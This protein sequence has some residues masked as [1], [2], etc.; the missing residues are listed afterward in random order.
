MWLHMCIKK[1]L[2]QWCYTFSLVYSSPLQAVPMLA[3]WHP[4]P[5]PQT[6]AANADFPAELGNP[7]RSSAPATG[8]TLQLCTR[9]TEV[10]EYP[11]SYISLLDSISRKPG[12]G[13]TELGTLNFLNFRS[14]VTLSASKKSSPTSCSRK[15]RFSSCPFCRAESTKIPVRIFLGI[16]CHRPPSTQLDSTCT[17]AK[18]CVSRQDDWKWW[19]CIYTP[20]R[21]NAKTVNAMYMQ[22]GT[23]IHGEMSLINGF[24]ISRHSCPS[25][26]AWNR[27]SM[28]PASDPK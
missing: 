10:I 3:Q 12:E 24:N 17:P 9:L 23:A 16:A 22:K 6:I 18:A 4:H 1:H 19:I 15:R 28:V 7:T 14:V 8:T 20:R 26:T 25:V 27:A 11:K 2:E 5:R 13:R 21:N